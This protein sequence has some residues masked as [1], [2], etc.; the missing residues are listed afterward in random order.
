MDLRQGAH[1]IVTT[2]YLLYHVVKFFFF[3]WFS[4]SRD[5]NKTHILYTNI[6]QIVSRYAYSKLLSLWNSGVLL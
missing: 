5:V 1:T 3:F 4:D 6:P 2:H